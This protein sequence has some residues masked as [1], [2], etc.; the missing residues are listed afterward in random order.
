[1]KKIV[2]IIVA[3]IFSGV[4]CIYIPVI[5]YMEYSTYKDY[6]E[7]GY[8]VECTAIAVQGTK[9]TRE[10]TAEYTDRDGVPHT[11]TLR[12]AYAV[13]NAGDKFTAL[14]LPDEPDKFWI[15]YDLGD[16]IVRVIIYGILF[17]AGLSLP[18]FFIFTRRESR[19]LKERGRPVKATI[20]KAYNQGRNLRCGIA[21]FETERGT[22]HTEEMLLKN[23]Q[24]E[25]DS[26]DLIYCYNDKGK[27]CWQLKD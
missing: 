14:V 24:R 3:V 6:T 8:Q 1:M 21:V 22:E 7:N 5:S 12:K 18:L 11:Y 27:L 16:I 9:K 19:L 15:K 23:Y 4:C 25:G 20:V 2:A 17:L 10:V 26:I 13:I